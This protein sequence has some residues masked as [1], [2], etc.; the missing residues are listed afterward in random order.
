MR[1]GKEAWGEVRNSD[2][3]RRLGFVLSVQKPPGSEGVPPGAGIGRGRGSAPHTAGHGGD[4]RCEGN[5]EGLAQ[6]RDCA[7]GSTRASHRAPGGSGGF[8][9]VTLGSRRTPGGARRACERVWVIRAGTP[10]MKWR[11]RPAVHLRAL[12]HRAR[13]PGSPGPALPEAV[14]ARRFP[15]PSKRGG[16]RR[17]RCRSRCPCGNSSGFSRSGTEPAADRF[18]AHS[19]NH[20]KFSHH[21]VM[22]LYFASPPIRTL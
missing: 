18:G 11:I 1:G 8:S 5:R 16:S 21:G 19:S 12:S 14:A 10:A 15:W 20:P 17:F 22:C 13:E 6:D 7:A 9:R 2:P 3:R 4:S